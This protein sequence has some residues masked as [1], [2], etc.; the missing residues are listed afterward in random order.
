MGIADKIYEVVKGMPDPEAKR[1]LEYAESVR[2]GTAT[3]VPAQRQVNLALF[4]LYRGRYD[5][6]KIERGA[7]RADV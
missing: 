7:L 5:G 2:A 6:V 3:V 4:R 1:I